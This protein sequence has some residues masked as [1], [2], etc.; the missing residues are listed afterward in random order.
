MTAH[1]PDELQPRVRIAVTDMGRHN[2]C[3]A[4][5]VFDNPENILAEQIGGM[6]RLPVHG[7]FQQEALAE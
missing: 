1:I 5:E 4:S 3:I 6:E 7:V 2:D